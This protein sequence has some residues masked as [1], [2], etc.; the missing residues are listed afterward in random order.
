LK[1]KLASESGRE[2]IRTL[3]D[4]FPI[5]SG[6]IPYETERSLIGKG[7]TSSWHS[8]PT[9]LR[10]TTGI[11]TNSGLYPS[12]GVGVGVIVG[13][14]V[15]VAVGVFDGVGVLDAVGVIEGVNVIVGGPGVGGF[16]VL[17]AVGGIRVHVRVGVIVGVKVLVGVL[18]GVAVA[19]L[20][21]VN[22]NVGLAVAVFVG[23]IA[24]AVGTGSSPGT[25][26]ISTGRPK[27]LKTSSMICSRNIPMPSSKDPDP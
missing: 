15:I 8:A 14:F 19:V 22:S 5:P 10:I 26:D 7:E 1:A 17:V 2:M 25:I 9:C 24:V 23:S 13:V 6:P 16:L 21:G 12:A 4:L 18:V 27:S 3:P 11:M 20:V